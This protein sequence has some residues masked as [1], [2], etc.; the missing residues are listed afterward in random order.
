MASSSVPLQVRDLEIGTVGGSPLV[1]GVSFDVREG[2]ILGIVG[3]SGA[4]KSVTAL[5]LLG[6]LPPSLHVRGGSVEWRGEELVGAPEARLRALRRSE[7][8][9]VFQEAMSAL[10]PCYRVGRQLE[11]ALRL[12]G[13]DRTVARR[14]SLELL[15]EV[16]V[17]EPATWARRFPYE[18]SG[19]MRQRA[20]IAMALA[21]SPRLLIADEPTSSLDVT[22]QAQVMAVLARLRRERGLSIIL[23]SHDLGLVA[24]QV[25]RLVVFS[26]GRVIEAGP[27]SRILEAPRDEVTRALTRGWHASRIPTSATARTGEGYAGGEGRPVLLDVQGLAARAGSTPAVRDV[28]LRVGAG[29]WVALIGESGCGKSTVA[30]AL[31]GLTPLDEGRLALDGEPLG[32]GG[33]NPRRIRSDIQLVLQD[34]SAALN[35]RR[36]VAWSV[37]R[38]LEIRGVRGEARRSRVAELLERV[39]LS[40]TD[41]RRR[42]GQL[43]GGERQRAALARA[44]AVR[45]RLLILDE[46][47]S[48]LDAHR[49]ADLA[50]FLAELQQDLGLS[51]LVISHDLRSVAAWAQRIYV[52]YLGRVVE[53]GSARDVLSRPAHPYTADLVGSSPGSGLDGPS[54]VPPGHVPNPL[55]VPTGCPY[56]PRCVLATDVCRAA[57]PGLDAV[58]TTTSAPLDGPRRMAA[59]YHPLPVG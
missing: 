57:R 49:R 42:P 38:P 19:G 6:L 46:P 2:E 15:R 35:P 41:G 55:D 54:R 52:V 31:V 27:V 33:A 9:V 16:G 4:G 3:P 36:T 59:C 1:K 20:L 26:S 29:E 34:S 10:H 17:P 22:I 48:S 51:Y 39:G 47:F 58:A 7:L 28:S 13:L 56:H 23:I 21:G 53:E 32:V 18:W 44:L 24:E 11:G 25:D 45:P 5:S 37:G 8:G 40:P 12:Q 50:D 30:R 14:A 43:S